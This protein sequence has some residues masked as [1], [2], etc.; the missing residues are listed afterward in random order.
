MTRNRH[1]RRLVSWLLSVSMVASLIVVAPVVASGSA[2]STGSKYPE[3]DAITNKTV[4]A[5]LER[6]IDAGKI[7]APA[8]DIATN[9]TGE[10]LAYLDFSYDASV[11]GE[12]DISQLRAVYDELDRVDL[13]YTNAWAVS[14][15]GSADVF[16]DTTHT[17]VGTNEETGAALVMVQGS[18]NGV[19]YRA[20]QNQGNLPV[21]DLLAGVQRYDVVDGTA[22]TLSTALLDADGSVSGTASVGD[23]VINISS[24]DGVIPETI[25]DGLTIG[26]H[27][28]RLS[29]EVAYV[30]YSGATT[31][32]RLEVDVEVH[33][34]RNGFQLTPANA[35][36]TWGD[37]VVYTLRYLNEN[38]VAQQMPGQLSQYDITYEGGTGVS[39]NDA[40]LDATS[41]TFTAHVSP[42][43]T[44]GTVQVACPTGEVVTAPVAVE[45]TQNIVS[46][47][48]RE[49]QNGQVMG[50]ATTTTTQSGA[51]SILAGTPIASTDD[52]NLWGTGTLYNNRTVY[53]LFDYAG[54][55]RGYVS[56]QY[57][58]QVCVDVAGTNP[59]LTYEV[60]TVP[61]PEGGAGEVVG[62]VFTA[63]TEYDT[64]QVTV[65]LD[66]R[67]VS[68]PPVQGAEDRSV[69]LTVTTIQ[70]ERPAYGYEVFAVPG[71]VLATID[72]SQLT[73]NI[74]AGEYESVG[75][76]ENVDNRYQPVDGGTVSVVAKD[77]VTL[78]AT[79]Y[80]SADGARCV[81]GSNNGTLIDWYDQEMGAESIG[82]YQGQL[83]NSTV[84][85][86]TQSSSDNYTTGLVLQG[87]PVEAGNNAG[88]VVLNPRGEATVLE[89]QV[90]SIEEEI[91]D[92]L[93]VPEGYSLPAGVTT[94][95]EALKAETEEKSGELY[96]L[97]VA[98]EDLE[99]PIGA[100]T[101]VTVVAVT[102]HNS[103]SARHEIS[104]SGW[105]DEFGAAVATM[106][107]S[108]SLDFI[109]DRGQVGTPANSFLITATS[110]GGLEDMKAGQRATITLTTPDG[111]SDVLGLRLGPSQITG[112]YLLLTDTLGNQYTPDEINVGSEPG[113]LTY[114]DG[115]DRLP[116][117]SAFQTP[118]GR[119]ARAQVVP[120]YAFSNTQFYGVG[121]NWED[122]RVDTSAVE[123]ASSPD[124]T[125]MPALNLTKE[126]DYIGL[127][128][129]ENTTT[130][131]HTL[132]VTLAGAASGAISLGGVQHG[133]ASSLVPEELSVNVVDPIPVGV[134][135]A[136]DDDGSS[137][138][139]NVTVNNGSSV[140]GQKGD[141][142]PFV[143]N[144]LLSDGSESAN[145]SV[146]PGATNLSASIRL[147]E[148]DGVDDLVVDEARNLSA[149]LQETGTATVQVEYTY[150]INGKS[151]TVNLG[152]NGGLLPPGATYQFDIVIGV[153]DVVGFT[154]VANSDDPDIT[155]SQTGTQVA[156]DYKQGGTY[157]LYPVAV[158]GGWTLE[159][160]GSEPP[161]NVT[162]A[163]VTAAGRESLS[164]LNSA[165]FN[166]G[167]NAVTF[168]GTSAIVRWTQGEDAN[169]IYFEM[170]MLSENVGDPYT[171]TLDPNQITLRTTNN[172]A[173][174][175]ATTNVQVDVTHAVDIAN[176][177]VVDIRATNQNTSLQV[178]GTALL[179]IE[180]VMSNTTGV[181][182][183]VVN[184]VDVF[185]GEW[186]MPGMDNYG[187]GTG[188]NQ[189]QVEV[190]DASGQRVDGLTLGH[191][192]SPYENYLTISGWTS[193]GTYTVRLRT[194]NNA[195][196]WAPGFN[197]GWR[198]VEIVVEP[199]H[200]TAQTIHYGQVL[201]VRAFAEEAGVSCS[202]Y[203][204]VSNTYLD[205]DKLAVGLAT[206]VE[207]NGI[208]NTTVNIYNEA[209]SLV[210]DV[211]LTLEPAVTSAVSLN[212]NTGPGTRRSMRPD[213][214]LYL[215]WNVVYTNLSGTAPT[216][217]TEP[218][219]PNSW[220][221]Q[222][223]DDR[224]ITLN[225]SGEY[226]TADSANNVDGAVV[227]LAEHLTS[228]TTQRF[229][230]YLD[231]DAIPTVGN[232]QFVA[233]RTENGQVVSSPLTLNVDERN[234][235][236]VRESMSRQLATIT[237]A[238]SSNEDVLQ[239]V[240][241]S[242]TEGDSIL[243]QPV[244]MG[245]ATVTAMVNTATTNSTEITL[246]VN[247]TD[248]SA[249]YILTGTVTD[250]SGTAISGATVSLNGQT[251]ITGLDGR[252]SI[253]NLPYGTY[254]LTVEADGYLSYSASVPVNG[255]V[256]HNVR[257]T[258]GYTVSGTVVTGSASTGLSGMRVDV[259]DTGGNVVKYTTTDANGNFSV[260][261]TP[262]NYT[263]NVSGSGYQAS[264][265]ISADAT[266]GD[267]SVG[268]I[269]MMPESTTP[270]G[271]TGNPGV[272][273]GTN[274]TVNFDLNGG[275]G[276]G[277]YN[278]MTV[279]TGSTITL[280]TAPT[281]EGYTFTGWS[282]GTTVITSSTYTV[283]GAV[284]LTAQWEE[285]AA[286]DPEPTLPFVDVPANEWYYSYIQFVTENS[287]MNGISDTVFGPNDLLTRA[288]MVQILYNM[289]GRPSVSG[290]NSFTDVP[291]SEW[292]ATAVVWASENG[293]VMG[294]SDGSFL[295][296]D[297]ITR[298]DLMVILYRYAQF[299]GVDT[300]A[301]A[302]L[303]DYV[304]AS[305]VSGY[306][307]EMVAWAIAEGLVQGRGDGQLSPQGTATRAEMA[308]FITRYVQGQ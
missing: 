194:L 74:A 55:N 53:L 209:G 302:D 73:A 161:Q 229:W 33:V 175:T 49:Y 65:W 286:V 20:S 111:D 178:N 184:P 191:G 146:L 87:G 44:D 193:A 26:T 145:P 298:E 196:V 123:V 89:V 17:F 180:Y 158:N 19:V 200:L 230:A 274:V 140:N 271:G 129:E 203:E 71:N 198:E 264:T 190:Y 248:T 258:S 108:S 164:F 231:Q 112:V 289:E 249:R 124:S 215:V 300:S 186:V 222:Q 67:P 261:V 251:A 116:V 139:P 88:A 216:V 292:Y 276:T 268:N 114:I 106:V 159:Y 277:N 86:N 27:T 13:R 280:P 91:T 239:V 54:V 195:G 182:D 134:V 18:P 113:P 170:T 233:D 5:A 37:D 166:L 176:S 85:A 255:N 218:I 125:G 14:N 206:M 307:Q 245:T 267:V 265:G 117:N 304:D 94:Y 270:G 98:G 11:V 192:N 297:N 263:I 208:Y 48:L 147:K 172:F 119:G 22:S 252:Y 247:V 39:L 213:E 149:L 58:D 284:T 237:A 250:A 120:V 160:D 51:I 45:P 272:P 100:S 70:N 62:V 69:T 82:A 154:W 278:A 6:M 93:F 211:V 242:D 115:V 72:R 29:F 47:Q 41:L 12:I 77:W 257:L 97:N 1:F 238:R 273:G 167:T 181:G 303:N 148:V 59:G 64:N 244:G 156:V 299:K 220:T 243:L 138:T 306:A 301:R 24:L 305:Q 21:I 105:E 57:R 214:Q 60:V 90:R 16:V 78:V 241:Y 262:G 294:Y 23:Q 4:V 76:Y 204:E 246:T 25:M 197:N 254:M 221:W 259:V 240:R 52:T 232:F 201:D 151:G 102:N 225:L 285:N 128:G 177:N 199:Q 2:G 96:R 207:N 275:T 34:R 293:L 162:Y 165:D 32:R 38:M 174:N 183:Y 295:P 288:H 110:E 136:Y 227:Y 35:G 150:T 137:T 79:V 308:T 103:A 269:T 66:N 101:T 266:S 187:T 109:L 7:L 260:T 155:V 92:F 9:P 141:S 282:D 121:V 163:D 31:P 46:L 43:A 253:G 228:G 234:T 36:V 68:D 42:G 8:D 283:S 30:N 219:D 142:I 281:R 290:S 107:S 226:I 81:L 153:P 28:F 235:V 131:N 152:T 169:G 287:Y 188:H 210:A 168:A 50:D 189:L 157:K 84:Y 118:E 63:G 10:R 122:Y 223:A 205:A 40:R 135:L 291:A 75:R 133:Y 15:P 185:T 144:Y 256:T 296:T 173:A 279:L 179:R 224:G 104:T 61:H 132:T 126:G 56:A 202:N 3:L 212:V 217:V 171:V 143:P 236:Y 80:Y 130:G 95:S 99:V 83:S 127:Y